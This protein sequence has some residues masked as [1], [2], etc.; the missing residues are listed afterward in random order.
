MVGGAAG[1]DQPRGEGGIRLRADYRQGTVAPRGAR[2]PLGEHAPRARATAWSSTRPASITG[3]VVAV[4][5]DGRGDVTRH[6]RRLAVHARRAATSRRCCSSDDLHLHGQRRRHRH[7]RRGARPEQMVWT[8]RAGGTFSASPICAD[9][10]I[11]F[12]GEDGKT[13]VHRGRAASSRCSP[14]TARRR[15]HGHPRN[16]WQCPLRPNE[17]KPLQDQ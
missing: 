15:L 8:A 6:P 14:R 9:G 11:Y 5:P 1:A 3:Q 7:V 16:R 17:V 4:R 13:T 12:F 2:Q 10:R